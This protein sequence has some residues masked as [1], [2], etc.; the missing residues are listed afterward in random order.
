MIR[1]SAC[2]AFPAALVACLALSAIAQPT[3]PAQEHPQVGHP[4]VP[5]PA[6]DWP[7][8]KAED[9]ASVDSIVA[10]YY[11]STGGKA[12]APRDWDRFRS[13]F[14]P[15][16]KLIPARQAGEN[17]SALY[18]GVN[19]FIA[20]NKN[21]LEKSGFFDREAARRVETFGNIA[22]VWSTY[23]SRRD[24]DA[25]EPYSRGLASIQLLK[26]GNRWWIVNVFWEY[27]RADNPIPAKYL[28]T[29]KE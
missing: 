17:T 11:A 22:H 4:T 1:V 26:D 28:K 21:Y 16:A 9:V 19:D 27:E 10:A 3:E 23:E 13:L 24:A 12:N 5:R 29:V 6:A 7:K 2:I 8:P 20:Q 25:A 18:I 14:L 15:D